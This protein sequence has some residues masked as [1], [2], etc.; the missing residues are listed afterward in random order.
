MSRHTRVQTAVVEVRHLTV[1][2]HL[3]NGKGT[4][5]EIG[6]ERAHMN[7]CAHIVTVTHL[8]NIAA[9]RKEGTETAAHR[10][11]DIETETVIVIA[12]VIGTEIE[13]EE[14]THGLGTSSP[15]EH[16]VEVRGRGKDCR[17]ES[18]NFIDSKMSGDRT[19][20]IE[21]GLLKEKYRH[22]EPLIGT[23]LVG[24]WKG[25]RHRQR[26]HREPLIGT[27]LI[28]RWKGLMCRRHHYR[29]PLIGNGLCGSWEGV[30]GR[31]V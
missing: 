9:R 7:P 15:D 16:E 29:E 23:G 14:D 2:L 10:K 20:R 11:E 28:G 21:F 3:E 27:G 24:R 13:I 30:T 5:A 17:S 18:A 22:K 19:C 4:A 25:L 8:D 1:D 12:S 26:H 6:T 31:Q